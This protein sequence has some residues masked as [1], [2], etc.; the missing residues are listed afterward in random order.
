MFLDLFSSPWFMAST[1]DSAT[2][3]ETGTEIIQTAL[4]VPAQIAA[5]YYTYYVYF[6]YTVY[7]C[8]SDSSV[9]IVNATATEI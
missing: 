9:Y 6:V 5:V 4:D 7:M 2:D 3:S 8:T 1:I